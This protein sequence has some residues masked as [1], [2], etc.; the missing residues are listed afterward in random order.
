M[1]ETKLSPFV[2]ARMDILLVPLNPPKISISNGHYFSRVSTFWDILYDSKL[3]TKRVP[4]FRIADELVFGGN[5]VNYG[6]ANYGIQDLVSIVQT[7]SR[8]VRTRGSDV[9]KLLQVVENC[10]TKIVCLMHNKLIKAF[11]KARVMS[12][13]G[14][15]QQYG[16][17]GRI[18]D[19]LIFAVPFPTGSNLTKEVITEHYSRVW[20]E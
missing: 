18:R 5:K 10:P 4:D 7:Y 16:L 8:N 3:L 2:H 14:S 13:A 19:T 9:D 12:K 11:E 17:R 20:R 15:G 1:Q 6:N